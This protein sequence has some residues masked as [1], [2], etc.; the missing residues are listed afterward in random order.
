M[1]KG[2]ILIVMLLFSFCASASWAE[3]TKVLYDQ[4]F[5]YK[6]KD[7]QIGYGHVIQT[8]KTDNGKNLIITNRQSEQKFQRFGFTVKIAQQ[9]QFIEDETGAP[10]SFSSS[11]ESQG[12]NGEM[13][14]EFITSDRVKVLSTVNGVK[15]TEEIKLNK[16]ILFPYAIS[17]LIK[18]NKSDNI[19][20]ST[21]DPSVDFRI[22]N[23]SAKKVGSE[24]LFTNGLQG[25]FIKYKVSMNILPNLSSF[26]WYDADGRV[27]KELASILNLESIAVPKEQIFYQTKTVDILDQSLIPVDTSFTNPAGL[28]QV[29]YKIEVQNQD[30][31]SIIVSDDRQRIIQVTGNTAY[32]KVKTEQESDEKF[33]YPVNTKNMNEFL[34]TGPFIISND[35]EIKTKTLNVIGQE[36][37]AYKIVK[38]LEKWVFDTIT[39]KDFSVNFANSKEILKTKEG[40]CTEH[41][42]LLASMLRAAGIPSKVVIG[43][44]YTDKPQDAFGYHMWVKAYTGKWVNLDPSF[45]DKNF[46]PTHIALYETALNNVSDRT[47]IV[48]NIIKSF[49]KIKINILNSTQ[50]NNSSQ[51]TSSEQLPV[52]NKFNISN[53][54]ND[55]EQ[56]QNVFETDNLNEEL[57]NQAFINYQEG[58][59]LQAL[60][61]YKKTSSI[62]PYND[63]F[64]G[65]TIAQ[66]LAELGF[67]NLSNEKLNNIYNKEIWNEKIKEIKNIYFPKKLL[68][69]DKEII[70][71]D[72]VSKISFN[73]DRDSVVKIIK[74]NKDLLSSDFAH[75]ILAKASINC[76]DEKNA[77][78]VLK[79]IIAENPENLRYRFEAAQLYIKKND[80]KNAKKEMNFILSHK[81][82]DEGFSKQVN[83]QN[84]WLNFKLERKNQVKSQ[85][86]LAKYYQS[87][88]DINNANC[89][90][91]KLIK[92]NIADNNVYKL[93]GDIN[94]Q[95]NQPEIAKIYYNKALELDNNDLNATIAL[96]D[97]EFNNKNY[98]QALNYY[99]KAVKISDKCLDAINKTAQTYKILSKEEESFNFYKKA[100][101]IDR[102]NFQTNNDLG[103]LYFEIGDHKNAQ[104]YLTKAL[105][106]MPFNEKLWLTLAKIE[107]FNKNYFLAKTYLIP[108]THIN[109]KN[110]DYYYCMGIINKYNENFSDAKTD[111]NIALNIDPKHSEA[112]KELKE[113]RDK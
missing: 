70:L 63:D 95:T 71:A 112:L 50:I 49:S 4:Y 6:I 83:I 105:S 30:P 99:L 37:D 21:L 25:D 87:K 90:L 98:Q 72:A 36:K 111:F 26:E 43:L 11:T 106:V 74:E 18:D 22:I 48:L 76:G 14:G 102:T 113:L 13:S 85:Y 7:T 16:N 53:F 9:S 8:S 45:P 67:F 46:S 29:N 10:I 73:K 52:D 107:I 88:G 54:I 47:D 33:S 38:K 104:I 89:V 20:Y 55:N 94:I 110:P 12:E 15:K 86:Y 57:M 27:V 69:E 41:S 23:Y 35:P 93:L 42:I 2:F 68:K 31:E 65:I 39:T 78:I 28:E 19:E 109:I 103:M 59:I 62:I 40:D 58:N 44:I 51:K 1:R 5:I 32:L 97:M 108:V 34:K 64:S 80:L 24:S 77:L 82:S 79:N 17:R 91:D 3:D 61:K 75:Y 66:T 92:S 81:I 60:E 84:Q 100:L 101:N 56:D 96:G